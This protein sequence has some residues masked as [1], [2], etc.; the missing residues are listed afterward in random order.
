MD[1]LSCC[2]EGELS[3]YTTVEAKEVFHQ[4]KRSEYIKKVP[5]TIEKF[6][7]RYLVRR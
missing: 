3:V 1:Y 4:E 7:D 6:N 5:Q 2:E